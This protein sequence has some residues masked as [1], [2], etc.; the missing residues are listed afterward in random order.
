MISDD[1]ISYS[2]DRIRKNGIDRTIIELMYGG[3]SIGGTKINPSVALEKDLLEMCEDF[4]LISGEVIDVPLNKCIAID[5]ENRIYTIPPNAR[6]NR[7]VRDVLSLRINSGMPMYGN[8]LFGSSGSPIVDGLATMSNA[9]NSPYTDGLAQVRL[10][11]ANT[12]KITT[13]LSVTSTHSLISVE[14]VN[15]N[16]LSNIKKG[17]YP[18]FF[19]IAKTYI[20]S[21]IYNDRLRLKKTAIFG[22]HEISEIESEIDSYADA[23]EKYQEFID[24]GVIG[25]MLVYAD[26]SKLHNISSQQIKTY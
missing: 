25:K 10:V 26:E 7:D 18:K 19:E 1:P 15:K 5:L 12:F 24:S 8:I 3:I 23:A 16:R 2:R 22:G 13:S 11:D 17:S 20:Q 14:L 6:R 21:V 4:N 9:V